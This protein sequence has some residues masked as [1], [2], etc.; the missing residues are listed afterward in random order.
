MKFYTRIYITF[1]YLLN[2]GK[3][4]Q[5]KMQKNKDQNL[6]LFLQDKVQFDSL[7]CTPNLIH[8]P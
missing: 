6:T 8:T 1:Q 5:I 3:I 2:D 7:N 4:T